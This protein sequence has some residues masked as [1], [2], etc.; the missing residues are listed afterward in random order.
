MNITRLEPWTIMNLLNRDL[1][2]IVSRPYSTTGADDVSNTAADWVPAVDIHEEKERFV[3]R[4]DLPG[5]SPDDI[6]VNMENGVL[7]LAGQR[8]EE[9][10]D[11][12]DGLKRFERV[13]GK[14][15]RRFNLPETADAE[16][17]S[18]RCANGILEIS[19]PKAARVQ[20]RRISV[21]AA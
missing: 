15:Y 16:G 11:E 2:R 17:I 8:S 21:E 20:A 10:S 9:S 12:I 5:V 3:L 1:D 13:S 18:A 14:F 19:I 7:S 6:D 4:A